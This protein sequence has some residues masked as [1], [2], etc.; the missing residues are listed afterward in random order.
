MEMVNEAKS[1][2]YSYINIA[3]H[4]KNLK[5][6]NG[7]SEAKIKKQIKEIESLNKKL[8]NFTILK[9]AELNIAADGSVDYSKKILK[10]LDIPLAAVHSKFKMTKAQM[11][12][13]IITAMENEHVKVIAHPTGRLINQRNPYELDMEKLFDAAKS[14]NTILEINAFPERLDLKDT[15][16]REAIDHKIKLS[17]GS[18]SHAKQHMH[19]LP[20]GLAQ[21]R[22][23]YA[24]KKDII[25]CLTLK[26]LQKVIK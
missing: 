19:L 16:I 1:L 24:Q 15:A 23:G 20:M 11:T 13:R 2:G 14:T 5:I 9:G 25:N 26:K 6:A 12:K 8:K 17:L 4:A 22:R 18:D 10:Q 3:D 21:A 7:M